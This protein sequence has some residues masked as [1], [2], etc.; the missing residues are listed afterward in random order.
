MDTIADYF[1]K[2]KEI[3]LL[4][5]KLNDKILINEHLKIENNNLKDRNLALSK[6]NKALC[7][8]KNRTIASRDKLTIKHKRTVLVVC[9]LYTEGL[10]SLT[11][12]QIAERLFTSFDNVNVAVSA[13]RRGKSEKLQV[14]C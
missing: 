8:E 4:Q 9:E 5:K 2:D 14:N 13:I 3:A 12:K 1:S 6:R 7:D 11:I 10:L